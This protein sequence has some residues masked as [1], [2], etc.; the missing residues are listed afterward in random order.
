MSISLEQ[1]LEGAAAASGRLVEEI[2]SVLGEDLIGAWLRV[3]TG[4]GVGVGSTIREDF[5]GSAR[6]S[7]LACRGRLRAGGRCSI[8]GHELGHGS[9]RRA[10]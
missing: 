1:V 3:A 8:S 10:G 9:W 5:G 4:V 6:R 7:G 2:Q